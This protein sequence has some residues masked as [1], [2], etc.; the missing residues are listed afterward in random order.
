MTHSPKESRISVPVIMSATQK[1]PMPIRICCKPTTWVPTLIRLD[2]A[3]HNPPIRTEPATIK[4]KAG[5][6]Q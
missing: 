2:A 4:I 3:T 6:M 5:K 1:E